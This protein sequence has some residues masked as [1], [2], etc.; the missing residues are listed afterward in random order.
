MRR[1]D[2][3]I[4]SLICTVFMFVTIWLLS[5]V[6]INSDIV[7]P[8][9]K[10][11]SDFQLTDPV[12][13]YI[14]ESPP[15]DTNVVMVNIG[16][17]P[18]EGVAALIEAINAGK[19]KVIGIDA[20]FRKLKTGEQA[21]G[22]SLLAAAFSK[23]E[24]MV[25]VSELLENDST[26]IIEDISMSNP[27]FMQ[28]CSPGF[29]DMITE[30]RDFFKTSRDC[31]PKEIY[32]GQP[33][34]SFPTQM[35]M[36][37][38]SVKTKRFLARNRHFETINFQGN[39]DTRIEGVSTNSKIVFTSLDWSQVLNKEYD[40]DV[41]RNKIVIMG[42][43]GAQI[44]EQTWE[45]K[46]FTPLNQNYVGKANPD[47]YGVVVHA[48]ILSMILKEAYIND[49]NAALNLVLNVIFT[50]FMVWL[51]SWMYIRLE[52]WYDA[53]SF[54]VTIVVI[55]GLMGIVVMIF[56][57]YSFRFDITLASVALFLSGNFIEIYFGL[58]KPVTYRLS[59]KVLTSNNTVTTFD[60]DDYD[61]T[62]SSNPAQ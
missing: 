5:F 48:N 58:I 34:Y 14:R 60:S 22:D 2:I 43:M 31:T 53:F 16:N 10:T 4:D 30:G 26:G 17:L 52:M 8:I 37:Y 56:H 18:R 36:M 39:I 28:Y 24:N 38:D 21:L 23:V 25:L 3:F 45:D 44:G 50:F 51:F 11:L 15:E 46:F 59:R 62:D 47:M 20:F 6:Q 57:Y 35:A 32:K 13:S 55:C 29:A 12:F 19:P 40:P 49:M 61:K 1:K 27:Y 41:F 33:V 54:L 9:S 42:F 7:N